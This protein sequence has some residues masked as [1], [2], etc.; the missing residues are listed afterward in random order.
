MKK[1][2]SIRVSF[3]ASRNRPLAIAIIVVCQFFIGVTG[4]LLG[5]WAAL[6]GFV[7]PETTKWVLVTMSLL[8]FGAYPARYLK[9]RLGRAGY[10]RRQKRL[11]AW[12]AGLGWAIVF[13]AGNQT[14]GWVNRPEYS[15]ML[16]RITPIEWASLKT[17]GAG[18]P[19][20]ESAG[21]IQHSKSGKFKKWLVSKAKRRMERVLNRLA[22]TADGL[23]VVAKALISIMLL[24]VAFAA[25]YGV[26]FLACNV[27][28][29]GQLEMAMLVAAV[30]SIGVVAGLI[31]G[32]KFIWSNNKNDKTDTRHQKKRPPTSIED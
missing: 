27:A 1:I 12:L 19:K 32:L 21:H 9:S 20:L 14:P 7:L 16:S 10:Y 5:A 3:W 30:G 4:L 15:G 13:F 24:L 17:G 23:N 28:C 11:D 22:R 31:I 25:G 29:S 6:E 26:V 8:A 2:T 18:E